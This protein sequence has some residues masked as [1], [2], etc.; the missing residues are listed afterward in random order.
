MTAL[1]RYDEEILKV[2]TTE[3]SKHSSKLPMSIS[4]DGVKIINALV[5]L[6]TNPNTKNFSHAF[7]VMKQHTAIKNL[8]IEKVKLPEKET[9]SITSIT[10]VFV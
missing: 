1:N 6:S 10:V 5:N 3:I 2:V 8:F 7:E 9:S 4:A